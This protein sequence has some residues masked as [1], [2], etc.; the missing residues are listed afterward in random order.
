MYLKLL[1]KLFTYEGTSRMPVCFLRRLLQREKK[2]AFSSGALL[3]EITMYIHAF[4]NLSVM[5]TCDY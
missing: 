2:K 3:V 1:S 5:R 4:L